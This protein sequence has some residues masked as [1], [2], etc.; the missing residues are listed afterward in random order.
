MRTA[1]GASQR[2]G[3][4]EAGSPHDAIAQSA[5]EPALDRTVRFGM[6]QIETSGFGVSNRIMSGHVKAEIL[7]SGSSRALTHYESKVIAEMTKCST[8]NIGGNGSQTDMQLAFLK[9]RPKNI[10][11]AARLGRHDA[12]EFALLF[13]GHLDRN[14]GRYDADNT[15]T[16][17]LYN[18][19]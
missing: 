8:F 10:T 2:A 14:G 4:R 1:N 19:I 5:G 6:H 13:R 11:L 12:L 7:I 3:F 18:Y 9:T 17:S 15:T 16:V